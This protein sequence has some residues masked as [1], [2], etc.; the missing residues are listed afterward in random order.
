L[1]EKKRKE[2]GKEAVK[3][4]IGLELE[5]NLVQSSFRDKIGFFAQEPACILS[6]LVHVGFAFKPLEFD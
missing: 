2:K 5:W 6:P 4:L 3:G 1:K